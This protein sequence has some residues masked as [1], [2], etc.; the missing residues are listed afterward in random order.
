MRCEDILPNQRTN[1]ADF[2]SCTILK[3]FVVVGVGVFYQQTKSQL[4]TPFDVMGKRKK[5]LYEKK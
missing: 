2:C 4:L 5:H 1:L 3:V